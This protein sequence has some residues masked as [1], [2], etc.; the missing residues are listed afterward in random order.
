[1]ANW[2]KI[3][4]DLILVEG[5]Y[6]DN[7]YDPGGETRYGITK[8]V[9]RSHGYHGDMHKLT[10]DFANKVY[11]KDYFSRFGFDKIQN[12][13][14]ASELFDFTVNSGRGHTATKFLQR[15]YNLLNKRNLLKE[16]GQLGPKTASTINNYKFY[17]SLHKVQNIFQ[18]MY[19]IS[20]AE[21]DTEMKSELLNHET[22]QGSTRFK[23][24]IR[25]WV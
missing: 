22:V 25:G 24:F 12:T 11:K 14:I 17:K 9:A 6:V 23:T 4:Q 5:G 21:H 20:L 1:M 7:K 15:A 8:E 3:F 19:Y 16:D 2:D 10:L 13:K 18:G